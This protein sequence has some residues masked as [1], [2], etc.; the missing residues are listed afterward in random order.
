[1]YAALAS[2]SGDDSADQ[3]MFATVGWYVTAAV[4]YMFL[5]LGLSPV[6]GRLLCRCWRAS[7]NMDLAATVQREKSST[8]FP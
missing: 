1:M 8:L 5:K 3:P 7:V 6:A 2:S 4:Q